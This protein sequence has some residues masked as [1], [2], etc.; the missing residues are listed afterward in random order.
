MSSIPRN[1][2]LS[3]RSYLW[4][5]GQY[6]IR[7]NF[8]LTTDDFKYFSHKEIQNSELVF[9][10]KEKKGLETFKPI[11][12]RHKGEQCTANLDEFLASSN[13][14]A[15]IVIKDDQILYENYFNGH[16]RESFS[17][18]FSVTKSFT[19]A[20]IGVAIDEGHIASIDDPIKQYLPE[21]KYKEVGTLTLKNLLKM[22]SGIGYTEGD[23][24]WTDDCKQ[25]FALDT[26]KLILNLKVK[27][28]TAD[29]FHY[30]DYHLHLLSLI[31]ERVTKKSTS[32]YFEEKIW[33]R[34]G[35][36]FPAQIMIDSQKCGFEKMASG[37][38]AR[39][40]DLAKFGRLYLNNG[41]LNGQ[42]VLSEKWIKESTNNEDVNDSKEF[43]RYYNDKP[44]GKWFNSGKAF[45][46]YLW[47]GYKISEEMNDYFAMGILGQ[48]I[49]ISPR[50]NAIAIRLGKDWG[51][52][53]WWP[54]IIK[55]LIDQV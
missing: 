39:A 11:T 31:L 22:D 55:E 51:I 3:E 16:N 43:F 37:L 23:F 25:Y 49:Y 46:K 18:V 14:T 26:R 20:L 12:Y 50:K 9:R 8:R 53:G 54:S 28:K 24:P 30:N 47:W 45:Y 2:V 1:E 4:R 29:F 13:T 17:K 38:C 44:W 35:T 27:D 34:I 5:Y 41:L 19:S 32:T 52:S 36:E 48:F 21:L 40:I 7:N 42:R 6:S 33:R 10:F 15:F